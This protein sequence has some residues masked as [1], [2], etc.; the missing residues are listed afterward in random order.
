MTAWGLC[1]V[2]M[3]VHVSIWWFRFMITPKGCS[4]SRELL[5][6]FVLHYWNAVI[7]F[8]WTFFFSYSHRAISWNGNKTPFNAREEEGCSSYIG[9][10]EHHAPLPTTPWLKVTNPRVRN[11]S[12]IHPFWRKE[13]QKENVRKKYN[14]VIYHVKL[15][16]V[17]LF[18]E[19]RWSAADHLCL[20]SRWHTTTY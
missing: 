20:L 2:N 7:D 4:D 13:T 12:A 1:V 19:S 15:R 16:I 9:Y 6:Y 8:C 14:R 5:S 3:C 11:D 18:K 10:K 17:K